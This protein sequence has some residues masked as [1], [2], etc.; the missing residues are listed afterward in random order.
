MQ[1]S[2]TV[3]SRCGGKGKRGS[4]SKMHHQVYVKRVCEGPITKAITC[5]AQCRRFRSRC[6]K[7]RRLHYETIAAY[8]RFWKT[9]CFRESDR[10]LETLLWGHMWQLRPLP[11][12]LGSPV[13]VLSLCWLLGSM[14]CD[15]GLINNNRQQNAIRLAS[16]L[17]A[18]HNS[19]GY[20]CPRQGSIVRNSR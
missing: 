19:V 14:S 20:S 13:A 11:V 8:T 5:M 18:S 1:C 9:L 3:C 4:R 15:L 7:Y 12:P 17:R 10:P 6:V 2:V 16:E